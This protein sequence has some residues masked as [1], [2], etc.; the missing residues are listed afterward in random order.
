LL[1]E[2]QYCS[3]CYY[4][5]V[6]SFLELPMNWKMLAVGSLAVL[7][8]VACAGI[9]PIASS[10]AR[11]GSDHRDGHRHQAGVFAYLYAPF[12][13]GAAAG[14]GEV[15]ETGASFHKGILSSFRRETR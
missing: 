12:G 2:F 13:Y 9:A 7:V 10:P 14:S 6:P 8:I 15:T 3:I 1:I 11:S 5:G 4:H